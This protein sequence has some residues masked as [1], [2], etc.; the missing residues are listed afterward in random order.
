MW[1]L[2]C[3]VIDNHGDLGVCWRLA[4]DLASRGVAVRLWVDAPEALAWMAPAGAPG[5]ELHRWTTPAPPMPEPGEVV[6]E[7]FGCD[8]PE[9][10]VARMRRERP[11]VWINLEYL[12]AEDWVGRCHGLPS[13]QASGPGAG[14]VKW[15]FYPGFDA[16]T[17][18][19]LR[20]PDLP[21]RQAGFDAAAW[22]AAQGIALLPGE[23]CL[24]LFCY[25]N[26]R[27][28]A[29]LDALAADAA[30][31]TLLLAT[32]GPAQQQVEAAM[33]GQRRRGALRV[34]AL[35]WLSQRAYDELLWSCDLN[36]V[37]GEDSAVRA[38]WAGAPF[39]WQLYPQ[40][41]GA[42]APKLEA[43]LDRHLDGAEPDLATALRALWR[44]WN[45]LPGG[46]AGRGGPAGDSPP[47]LATPPSLVAW[48]RHA[49][50]WRDRL[51]ARPDLTTA[52]LRFVAGRP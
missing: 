35:P 51:A 19:L 6:V 16:Q 28:A 20:E 15:F 41:D 1:D 7:A 38:Q 8:P 3:R 10:F 44:D 24:S 34:Q 4:V 14:L 11:P 49:V 36:F 45:G 17:G 21:A 9:A 29:L 33:Q 50:A 48:R 39:V 2:F 40:R 13:P 12:S 31:P 42:E 30:Q 5:V 52:L 25:Q 37:R 18:G 32:P 23:R 26:P 46:E 22:R 47:A 43:F 27:L